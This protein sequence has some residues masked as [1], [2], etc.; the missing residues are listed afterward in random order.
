MAGLAINT[1]PV[2][3]REDEGRQLAQAWFA[4]VTHV[5]GDPDMR[6]VER[7]SEVARTIAAELPDELVQVFMQGCGVTPGFAARVEEALAATDTGAMDPRAH[8]REIRCPVHLFHGL[9]D[10]VIPSSQMYV[11]AAALSHTNPQTYL[12]GLYGH[13]RGNAAPS[14]WLQLPALLK[15]ITTMARMVHAMV[16]SATRRVALRPGPY[17][18]PA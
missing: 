17:P 7:F 9:Q 14:A 6:R 15:D 13:S 12:T 8:L 18:A 3:F 5:C 16:L 4:F 1:V 10:D 2:L 11:L